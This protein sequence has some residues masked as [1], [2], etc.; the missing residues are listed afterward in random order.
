MSHTLG[1]IAGATKHTTA[2]EFKSFAHAVLL[3]THHQFQNGGFYSGL[4]YDKIGRIIRVP[5]KPDRWDHGR[6]PKDVSGIFPA[7]VDMGNGHVQRLEFVVRSSAEANEERPLGRN[8]RRHS[9]H[10]I[11]VRCLCGALV[12][13]GRIAQHGRAVIHSGSGG[14]YGTGTGDVPE[15]GLKGKFKSD[16][17]HASGR[18]P[19]ACG[20]P[21]ARWHGDEH[22]L[23]TYSCDACYRRAAHGARKRTPL[24][25]TPPRVRKP[26]VYTPPRGHSSGH[27]RYM[28]DRYT[29]V[30]DYVP[31]VTNR[32]YPT[33]STG[34]FSTLVRGDF[35]SSEEAH[36][37]ASKH[38]GGNPYQ[39]EK[40]RVFTGPG[41][42][43]G[44]STLASI[45]PG[46]RVTIL[47]PA[48]FGRHGQ[49]WKEATGRAV[50]RGDYGWVL[51][52]GGKRG[53][54]GIASEENLVRVK[55]AR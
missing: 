36:G 27:E 46:D 47:V 29:V 6:I 2:D 40:R 10:R 4:D 12:P 9:A 14:R 13:V 16:W 1:R 37:W 32:W 52:M 7:T 5:N 48:G 44:A 22:G 49:E 26:L 8:R 3:A 51:D 25:Y 17:G 30:L 19:C 35:A 11:F 55:H 21:D 38:L 41:Y 43:A 45:R 15:R 50:M 33:S 23:R 39:V 42:S 34:P 24:V 53:R 18:P 20:S 31:G 28:S 54:P